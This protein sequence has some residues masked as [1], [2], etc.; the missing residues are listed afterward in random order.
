MS[1]HNETL[2]TV[3][4]AGILRVICCRAQ[5]TELLHYSTCCNH[6]ALH[7]VVYWKRC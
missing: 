6:F 2:I 5:L 7:S 3:I 4:I 1:L